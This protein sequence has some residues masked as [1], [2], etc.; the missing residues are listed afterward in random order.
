MKLEDIKQVAVVA[1]IAVSICLGLVAARDIYR[2]LSAPDNSAPTPPAPPTARQQPIIRAPVHN[3]TKKDGMEYLYQRQLSADERNAGQVAPGVIALM[4]AG[5]RDGLHQLHMRDGP[6]FTAFECSNP[7]D[8][9]KAMTF[10]DMDY[11]RDQVYIERLAFDRKSIIGGAFEDALAG[12]LT[13][14]SATQAGKPVQRWMTDVGMKHH[15][16][17][18]ASAKP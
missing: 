3:Y 9:I 4:Y 17:A 2:A 1:L 8:V 14:Y 7:C 18:G 10:L 5:A 13:S 15:P 6:R 12:R 11:L 16:V